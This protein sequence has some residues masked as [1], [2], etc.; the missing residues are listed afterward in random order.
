V[1]ARGTFTVADLVDRRTSSATVCVPA[2][3]EAPTIGRTVRGLVALRDR[4]AI[5]EVVV[6][7]G[8]STDGTEAL[9]AEAGATVHDVGTH[10]PGL[11]PVLGKGD[12][13]WRGLEAVTTDVVAF[14]DADLTVDLG[15][16]ISGLLGPIVTHTREA[17]FVK[18]AFRRHHP[19][20]ISDEDPYDGGRVTETV[21]RPLI[22]LLRPDLAGF[23]QP[24]GGQVG[25]EVS[26]LRSIPFLTGYA[27][28]I[29]M[30]LDV[31]DRVG[32]DAVAPVD[33]GDL[34]TR[35]RTTTELAPMSQEVLYGFLLRA[36]PGAVAAGWRPYV[37]PHL[38]GGFDVAPAT[39]VERPPLDPV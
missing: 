25:A 9:A 23:Y 38:E 36:A 16:M 31:V 33:L 7:A 2:R 5:D 11:G 34:E 15:A 14:V 26:L 17:R 39:V 30:L 28:E 20:F 32:L 35:P 12:A 19:D 1:I 27:V 22:N 21:A 6:L 13:M 37:R 3:D 8:D 4:G 29:G 10:H 24:L 18:G